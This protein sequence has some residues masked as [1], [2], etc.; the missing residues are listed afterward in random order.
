MTHRFCITHREPLLPADWYDDCISLGEFQRDSD[1][2]VG[3]LDKFWDAA[4]PLA[5]GAAG[6]HVLPIAI[7]TSA[8]S[9][10]LIEVSSC[11]KRV[12]PV[13][14]GV[15]A[16]KYPTMRELSLAQSSRLAAASTLTPKPGQEF[17]VAQP[18][19]F[20]HT[21]LGQ[22]RAAH[23]RR[24]ILDYMSIAVECDVLDDASASELLSAKH[25]IPGGTEFG[26]YPRAWLLEVLPGIEAVGRK[27]LTR[28]GDRVAKYNSHQVRA[29]GFLSERLGSFLLLR[30]LK[31][32][33]SNAIPLEVFGFMTTIVEGD[34][35]YI[36]AR[37]DQSAGRS[38]WHRLLPKR[39][40]R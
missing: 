31:T 30:H 9:A 16:R 39:M 24:D 14:E 35:G 10:E 12:L 36:H 37:G 32:K 7:E 33:Y 27:F 29:V 34:A 38:P 6:S 4:R 20:K 3:Q 19:Y 23:H 26:T 28:Y 21:V 13:R 18:L 1:L 40:I 11:R 17:L 25:F 15:A 8:G 2:H 22:Y 5:Y